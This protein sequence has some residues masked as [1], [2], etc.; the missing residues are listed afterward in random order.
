MKKLF[1]IL[2]VSVFA[3][4]SAMAQAVHK[5]VVGKTGIRLYNHP[6][7]R[8]EIILPQ[9]KGYN[10]YKG[11][12]HVHTIYSDG[13]VTPRERVREAWYDGLDIIALT[14]HLELRSYEKFMLKAHAPYNK[15]G[16]PY[17][18]IRG[19][20]GNKT[21]HTT[22]IYCD[23]D[24]TYEEAVQ[25]AKNEEI[26]VMV[27]RGT[28]IWRNPAVIGEYNALFLT[29]I[30]DVAKPDIIESLKEARKQGAIIIHNHP[31]WRRKTMDKSEM[32]EKI[33]AEK[34]VDG[35]EVIGGTGPTLYP[36]MIDRCVDEKLTI[37]SNTDTHRTSAQYYPRGGEIFRSMTFILAKE[38]TEKAIKDALLK[39]RTIGYAANHLIG[40]E[41]WLGEFLNA[42]VECKVV[43]VN[44]KKEH[45]AFQL[46]NHCSVPFVFRRGKTTYTLNPFHSIRVNFGKNKENGKYNTPKFAVENMWTVGDKHPVLTIEIDK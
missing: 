45:R 9:V 11:D 20:A 23:L 18:Y 41:M 39:R 2:A 22:P 28:E 10:I 43:A 25:Y 34:L 29:D 40:E 31:G 30:T 4:S 26:P 24:A 35:I 38:C 6:S 17:Q 32:Q 1:L 7:Y 8:T 14:D 15:D 33:Y 16:K 13:E 42:A 46:T 5:P 37:F 19:G 3:V 44:D 27:V 12:F 36:K 21:D